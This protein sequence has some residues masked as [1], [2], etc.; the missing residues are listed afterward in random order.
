M[1]LK[2]LFIHE[3]PVAS[4][5]NFSCT[6]YEKAVEEEKNNSTYFK[7]IYLT[8]DEKGP[9]PTLL[10]YKRKVRKQIHGQNG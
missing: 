5:C 8:L 9:P 2:N 7:D 10:F 1:V 6:K 4:I 3:E